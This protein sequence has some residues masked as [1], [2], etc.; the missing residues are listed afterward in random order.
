MGDRERERERERERDRE[1]E[2]E[3]ERERINH[4]DIKWE[5]FNVIAN[6][7]RL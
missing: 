2:R 6:N 4:C 1:R 3:R 5:L 7:V